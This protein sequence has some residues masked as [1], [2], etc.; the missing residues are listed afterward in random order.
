MRKNVYLEGP[1]SA[2][3]KLCNLF[4]QSS[5]ACFPGEWRHMEA[6]NFSG[7]I[8]SLYTTKANSPEYPMVICNV[9]TVVKMMF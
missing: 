5:Y 7:E 4:L 3:K 2:I 8:W 1:G 6:G 9:T